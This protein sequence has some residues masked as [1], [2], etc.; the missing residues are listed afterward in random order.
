MPVFDCMYVCNEELSNVYRLAVSLRDAGAG[1]ISSPRGQG[2]SC[3]D[4]VLLN[5]WPVAVGFAW[6]YKAFMNIDICLSGTVLP[7]HGERYAVGCSCVES[8]RGG[9]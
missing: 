6:V 2:S 5:S 8:T 7:L 9:T 3:V 4:C 1:M